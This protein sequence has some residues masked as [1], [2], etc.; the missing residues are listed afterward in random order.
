MAGAIVREEGQ[1]IPLRHSAS[2][3]PITAAGTAPGHSLNIAV[4]ELADVLHTFFLNVV[5][6]DN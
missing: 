3:L 4:N 1:T 2:R 6:E 5:S